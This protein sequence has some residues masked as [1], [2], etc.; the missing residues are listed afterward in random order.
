MTSPEKAAQA[1]SVK[2]PLHGAQ[3]SSPRWCREKDAPK[4]HKH[5]RWAEPE[6]WL[7]FP[8]VDGGIRTKDKAGLMFHL[9]H[10]SANPQKD[11][12]ASTCGFCM[13]TSAFSCSAGVAV[14]VCP[15]KKLTIAIS[16]TRSCV[17]ASTSQS[18]H[19]ILLT[20]SKKSKNLS[21]LC[22]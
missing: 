20:K 10:N 8:P 4:R 11:R 5:Q 2:Q 19:L 14:L 3:P 18:C 15:S 22:H 21:S 1:K 6:T 7:Y 9:S 17:G 16:E 12:A 13:A